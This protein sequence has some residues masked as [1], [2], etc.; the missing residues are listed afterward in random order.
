MKYSD[1]ISKP[2]GLYISKLENV[3]WFK[4][5]DRDEVIEALNETE[6]NLMLVYAL[7]E[8]VFNE[9][10]FND[11]KSYEQFLHTF[12]IQF[13]L[14]FKEIAASQIDNLITLTVITDENTYEYIVDTDETDE[15]F[16]EN[17]ILDFMNGEFLE[18]EKIN[19]RFYFLPEIDENIALYFTHPTIQHKAVKEGLIPSTNEFYDLLDSATENEEEI[20]N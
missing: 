1:L 16:D 7:E 17:L 19:E 6:N 9:D 12:L 13:Q 2:V 20:D 14:N 4:Y 11:A 10:N 18:K 15:Y 5:A 3:S 8:F